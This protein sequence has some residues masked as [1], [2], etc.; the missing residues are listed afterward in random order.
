MEKHNC[1]VF[2]TN[3]PPSFPYFSRSVNPNVIAIVDCKSFSH[4][5]DMEIVEK[6]DVLVGDFMPSTEFTG[7][8]RVCAYLDTSEPKHA[9][10]KSFAID[11]LK[12][13]SK[14]WVKELHVNLHK[15]F[16]AIEFYTAKEAA[17]PIP[18]ISKTSSST[19]SP[20]PS[21]APTSPSTPKSSSLPSTST[22]GSPSNSSPSCPSTSFMLEIKLNS[23]KVKNYGYGKVKNFNKASK[24]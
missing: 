15:F 20:S 6:K 24:V 11:I 12:R 4:L 23:N 16:D 21:S 19:S 3:F 1:T 9:Q 7:D 18:H 10:I 17:H 2:R 14:V 8:T 22:R 5:F 13:G